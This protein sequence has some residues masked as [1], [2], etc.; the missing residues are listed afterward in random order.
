MGLGTVARA[1]LVLAVG[2]VLAYEFAAGFA[3]IDCTV[4]EARAHRGRSGVWDVRAECADGVTREGAIGWARRGVVNRLAHQPKTAWYSPAW[5][6]LRAPTPF[7]GYRWSIVAGCLAALAWSPLGRLDPR[8]SARAAGAP[9]AVP[10]VSW[11][12]RA[13]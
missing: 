11:R 12:R 8:P 10:D 7:Q 9:P 6:E 5:G 13:G 3:T 2:S 4:V 1:S